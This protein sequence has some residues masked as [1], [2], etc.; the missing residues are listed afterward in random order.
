MGKISFYHF[1]TKSPWSKE[2]T[3]PVH[4]RVSKTSVLILSLRRWQDFVH[5]WFSC[6]SRHARKFSRAPLSLELP[7]LSLNTL[8]TEQRG[9]SLRLGKLWHVNRVFDRLTVICCWNKGK[10]FPTMPNLE[11]TLGTISRERVPEFPG[12]LGWR[13]HSRGVTWRWSVRDVFEC[14]AVCCPRCHVNS[15]VLH[16]FRTQVIIRCNIYFLSYP[17]AS[18]LH[19]GSF[20]LP[21]LASLF[22]WIFKYAIYDQ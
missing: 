19:N 6:L 20:G 22:P 16:P 5:E 21:F 15:A 9:V 11:R 1:L 14:C 2:E 17:S 3:L 4:V 13:E 8:I 18:I 12:A 10:R 7:P